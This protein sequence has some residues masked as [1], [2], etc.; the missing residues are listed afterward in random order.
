VNDSFGKPE[1]SMNKEIT[2]TPQEIIHT[3]QELRWEVGGDFH[4]HLVE[5]IYTDAAQIADRA[6]TRPDEKPISTAR[7]TASSPA[8][9]W[10]SL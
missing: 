10:V 3:A 7:L 4:E 2:V 1:K 9:G 6:I 5:A 8:V